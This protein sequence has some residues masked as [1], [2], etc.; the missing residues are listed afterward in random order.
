MNGH[1]SRRG[2]L[3]AGAAVVGTSTI[4]TLAAETPAPAGSFRFCFNTSTISGQR[5]SLVQEID[6]IA[7]VGYNAIEPWVRELE[8]HVKGGGKLSDIRKRVADAGLTVEDAIGFAA[9]IPDDETERSK[10]LEQAK[11]DMELVAQVGGKRMAAPP[12]GGTNRPIE[13]AKIMERYCKLAEIAQGFGITPQLE[14][15]GFSK[16]LSKLGDAALVATEC[17]FRGA[18]I[19]PDVFHMYKG[20]SSFDGL[21]LLNGNAVQMLHMNDYPADPPRDRVSDQQRI[22]PGDGIAPLVQI[23]KDLRQVNPGCILSLELFNRDYYK[24]DAEFVARTGLEKM[25]A[26]AAKA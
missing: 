17:G 2:L 23:L 21:R 3:A 25:K 20:N 4:S 8:A 1:I 14:I 18:C 10:G 24:L 16:T 7:K 22:F 5:L 26:I 15:W 11:R 13:P 19:L 12:V 9:W 6:L